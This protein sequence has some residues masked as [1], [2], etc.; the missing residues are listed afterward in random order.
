MDIKDAFDIMHP[1]NDIRV[2]L[3]GMS[4]NILAY[5]EF[6]GIEIS[7]GDFTRNDNEVVQWFQIGTWADLFGVGYDGD[8]SKFV[9]ISKSKR[10]NPINYTAIKEFLDDALAEHNKHYSRD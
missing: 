4:N 3:A 6:A 10:L 1:T 2:T 5:C 7:L 8:E 9:L